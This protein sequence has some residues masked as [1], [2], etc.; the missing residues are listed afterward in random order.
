MESFRVTPIDEIGVL[1]DGANYYREL[2]RALV[3]AERSI[4]L[5]GRQFDSTVALLRGAA[6][7][8]AETPVTLLEL[9]KHLLAHKP[10]LQVRILAWAFHPILTME[11][12]WLQ[13]YVFDLGA[14]DRA[15]F[16]LDSNHVAVG[17]HHQKFISIDGE[18]SFVGGMDVCEDRWDERDHQ[19]TQ[20]L[21]VSRGK[22]HKPFHDVQVCIRGREF[23]AALHE[24]FL[25]RWERA[26]G[27]PIDPA[28][29][30]PAGTFADHRLTETQP[31][32]GKEVSLLRTD[33]FGVPGGKQPCAEIL[34]AH[35]SA[36][37]GAQTLIYAETQYLTSHHIADALEARMR[38]GSRGKLDL[39]FLLNP[40]GETLKETIAMGLSQAAVL[41]RLR[42]VAAETGHH[43]GLYV[44]VPHCTSAEG[45]DRTTYIHS[46][47]M[48]IDDRWICVG[49][50]NLNNRSMA[51]DSELDVLLSTDDAND[52]LGRSLAALR[53]DLLAE[54]VGGPEL[55]IASGLVAQLD[56]LIGAGGAEGCRLRPHPSPTQNE[57]TVIGILDPQ[58]IPFDPDHVEPRAA[59]VLE[60]L[61]HEL[62]DGPS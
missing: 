45:P 1:I 62:L 26:G 52:E 38:D 35:V 51:V 23:A 19:A 12:E 30:A 49:S 39:V 15:S 33:P 10:W 41:G 40:E 28:T 31:L 42:T 4:V 18:L 9:L 44:T 29:L 24:L 21:R 13:Q 56:A 25:A 14:T 36:I 27:E 3:R 6:A 17:C 55:P 53:R 57:L 5:A 59:P 34:D 37:A 58:Q 7:D 20:P 48:I 46:K 2:Y 8:R 43:L 60:R 54:H 16:V 32:R 47:L 22:F 61:V 50:A 11:R